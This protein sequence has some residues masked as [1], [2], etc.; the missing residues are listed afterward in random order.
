M[1]RSKSSS[2]LDVSDAKV[3]SLASSVEEV[4]GQVA[5]QG[6]RL[7]GIA[8]ST[9]R[10]E[11]ILVS[12]ASGGGGPSPRADGSLGD[13]SRGL[14][15][16]TKKEPHTPPSRSAGAAG[17]SSGVRSP[18]STLAETPKTSTVAKL[19]VE[20]VTLSYD[21]SVNL[22]QEILD[23]QK[24]YVSRAEHDNFCKLFHVN[25]SA[26]SIAALPWR[27]TAPSGAKCECI[28]VFDWW[29]ALYLTKR[30]SAWKNISTEVGVHTAGI[31]QKT[32][33]RFRYLFF[34][35]H[36]LNENCSEIKEHSQI[37]ADI[38]DLMHADHADGNFHKTCPYIVAQSP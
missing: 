32:D 23:V 34:L 25:P 18:A 2:K 4:R 26:S 13:G 30:K 3:S 14:G 16:P 20:E 38:L 21:W 7:D 19:D 10:I 27:A 15:G 1:R 31:I 17:P 29:K 24:L 36:G 11:N 9:E 33:D 22:P 12:M 28:R 8:S 37:Q 5:H 35:L 6:S